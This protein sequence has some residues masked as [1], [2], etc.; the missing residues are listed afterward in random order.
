MLLQSG[1]FLVEEK[2][3]TISLSIFIRQLAFKNAFNIIA[4]PVFGQDKVAHQL[5]LNMRIPPA[6]ED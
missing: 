2:C 1:A 5:R 6:N 4:G 3:S